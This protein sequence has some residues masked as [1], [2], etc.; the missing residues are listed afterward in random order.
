M[1]R[2]PQCGAEKSESE[3]PLN[4][5]RSDGLAGWCR[6][7]HK[8]YRDKHKQHKRDYNLEYLYGILDEEMILKSQDYKC[9]ICNEVKTLVPDHNHKT[10]RFRA[11]ICHKCNLCVGL[12]ENYQVK[13]YLEWLDWKFI[14]SVLWTTARNKRDSKLRY[15]HNICLG[16]WEMMFEAQNGVCGICFKVCATGNNLC[17]DHDWNTLRI[18]GLLC[19]SCNHILGRDNNHDILRYI[20]HF[21]N[22]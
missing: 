21:S 4:K 20:H 7:C 13:E 17:V 6:Q 12:H 1:K 11:L 18:R 10:G 22:N 19:C 15:N 9:L 14:L 5:H 8:E 2:C 16:D 3:F